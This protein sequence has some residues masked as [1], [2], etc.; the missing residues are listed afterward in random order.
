MIVK[1]FTAYFRVFI[2]RCI[3]SQAAL[4]IAER[5]MGPRSLEACALRTSAIT[6]LYGA[7]ENDAAL[8]LGLRALEQLPSEAAALCAVRSAYSGV[9]TEKMVR[10]SEADKPDP[11]ADNVASATRGDNVRWLQVRAATLYNVA[12]VL[13]RKNFHELANTLERRS[14]ELMKVFP[15]SERP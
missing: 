9:P 8:Q 5:S 15:P 6:A 11:Q 10:N 7:N 4:L 2:P 12:E 3:A 13:R 14:D 1:T